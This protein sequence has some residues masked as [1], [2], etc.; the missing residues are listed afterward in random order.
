MRGLQAWQLLRMLGVWG[1][2]TQTA[3]RVETMTKMLCRLYLGIS[4]GFLQPLF[5]LLALFMCQH[6]IR[7]RPPARP[8]SKSYTYTPTHTPTHL[9]THGLSPPPTRPPT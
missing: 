1:V 8:N 4:L 5:L 2:H 7:C 9:P 6:T 3:P